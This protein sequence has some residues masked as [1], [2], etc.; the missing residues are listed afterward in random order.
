LHHHVTAATDRM[1]PSVG[2]GAV[3]VTT[4]WG[5]EQVKKLLGPFFAQVL[6]CC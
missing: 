1:A 6:Y 2:S 5:D 3:A 4:V